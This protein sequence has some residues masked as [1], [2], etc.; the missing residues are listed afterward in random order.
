MRVAERCHCQ[1]VWLF[2]FTEFLVVTLN[3]VRLILGGNPSRILNW[4]RTS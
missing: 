1:G 2:D 3:Y 4:V